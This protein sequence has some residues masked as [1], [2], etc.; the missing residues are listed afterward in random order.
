MPTLADF[1]SGGQSFPQG[2][3]GYPPM[4]IADAMMQGGQSFAPQQPQGVPGDI[5]VGGD[6]STLSGRLQ[7]ALGAKQPDLGGMAQDILAGRFQAQAPST[8][9]VLQGAVASLQ[10]QGY[11]PAQQFTNARMA[12]SMDML[13][14]IAT[15]Q[16]L[17]GRM[18][19]YQAMAA[20]G[21]GRGETIA[22]ANRVKAEWD[23][24]HPDQP[25]SIANAIE[26][27]SAK[28]G[29]GIA[30]DP[31]TGAQIAAPGA[32]QAQGQIKYGEQSGAN[33]SDLQY[34][35]AIAGG[36]QQQR[37]AADVNAAASL[38][39][40]GELGKAKGGAEVGLATA[41]TAMPALQSTIKDLRTLAQAATYTKGG[42][43]YNNVIRQLGL[44]MT[45]GGDARA[46]FI[47]RVNSYL[48]PSLK[49]NFGS[50]ITNMEINAQKAMFADPNLSPAEKMAQFDAFVAAKQ[51]SLQSQR[52]LVNALG[53]NATVNENAPGL[54][55]PGSSALPQDNTQPAA[56]GGATDWQEYFK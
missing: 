53:G 33:Q 25:M 20:N 26:Q 9:D 43:L 46:E 36:E 14:K 50:R 6:P 37:K 52:G 47:T 45:A 7:E 2:G 27:V 29:K 11:V 51:T 31:N 40:Q 44:P 41:E 10:N 22:M 23:A 34:K 28:Q 12:N 48:I 13:G 42:V 32:P 1:M 54:N 56:S 30:Y 38:A 3:Q 39:E 35:P 5:P 17:Q 15:M 18:Q 19:M 8:S 21:G 16:E 49:Q 55:L 24:A 4:S